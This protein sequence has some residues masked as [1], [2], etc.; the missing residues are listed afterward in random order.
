M[1]RDGSP[2]WAK[3]PGTSRGRVDRSANRD[4]L[5]QSRELADQLPLTDTSDIEYVL[6][7][8]NVAEGRP[9]ALRI[10]GTSGVHKHRVQPER[11]TS[12]VTERVSRHTIGRS[13][14]HDLSG[15]FQ[16]ILVQLLPKLANMPDKVAPLISRAETQ[17]GVLLADDPDAATLE[18]RRAAQLSA[19][20]AT[21]LFRITSRHA[22]G[23]TEPV[24]L[25]FGD[26][27]YRL[28]SGENHGA[29]QGKWLFA[30]CWARIARDDDAAGILARYPM[31][32]LRATGDGG[33]SDEFNHDWVGILQKAWLEGPVSVADRTPALDTTSEFGAQRIVDHLLRPPMEVFDAIASNDT[34]RFNRE[35]ANAL[36]LHRS[37]FDST[38]WRND[39][40]GFVS[41]PLLGLAC[42]AHDTHMRLEVES[43]YIPA[44]FIEAPDWMSDLDQAEAK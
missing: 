12:P 39:P 25:R 15:R 7:R 27:T 19:Q 18:T 16:Q 4:P 32:R 5:R 40:A 31:S 44:Y 23:S 29:H 21:G 42:W 20:L 41:I 3:Q 10:K 33:L 35:L 26:T 22:S 6:V 28:P 2:T 13:D 8:V 1:F 30:F 43:E 14:L 34:T 17:F 38:E 24:E 11:L 9:T 36:E 37:F